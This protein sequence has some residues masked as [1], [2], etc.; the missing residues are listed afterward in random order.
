MKKLIYLLIIVF[1]NFGCDA[2]RFLEQI[3]LE[4]EITHVIQIRNDVA[5]LPDE[6]EPF[7]GK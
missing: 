4:E 2:K 5:Y 7:T 1:F 6:N 3:G